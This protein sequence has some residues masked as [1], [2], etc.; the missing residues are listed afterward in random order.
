MME[1]E[2]INWNDRFWS[3]VDQRGPDDCWLWMAGRNKEGYGNFS[4]DYRTKK[5]HRIAYELCK[6]SI[7][8]DKPLV[9]HI[10]NNPP[11]VNPLHLYAG[12]K[13]DNAQQMIREGRQWFQKNPEKI[14][15]GDRHY[16]TKISDAQ[17]SKI[18]K[19]R[20]EGLKLD[21]IAAKYN[22]SFQHISAILLGK[23]RASPDR[24]SLVKINRRRIKTEEYIRQVYNM[25][26]SGMLQREI[27]EKLN[28]TRSNVNH[29]L[30]ERKLSK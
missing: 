28:I 8:H 21:D 7:P 5:A 26:S 13:V 27:A 17:I 22:V 24:E 19:M 10:C 15:R 23:F 4:I 30:N 3:K 20:A 6:G 2:N 25:R 14:S 12:T 16:L 18:F 29:I 11:C 9:C 1:R